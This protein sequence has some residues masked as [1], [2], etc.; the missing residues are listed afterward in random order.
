MFEIEYLIDKKGQAKA[1]VIPIEVWQQVFPEK[2]VSVDELSERLEDYCLNRAMN[3][4][5]NSPILDREAALK[6]LEE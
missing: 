5:E 2:E 1:V 6:F 3:E 4:A